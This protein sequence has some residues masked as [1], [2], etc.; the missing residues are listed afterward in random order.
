VYSRTQPYEVG[1]SDAES[2]FESRQ[3]ADKP[4]DRIKSR[5][6]NDHAG[7]ATLA[8]VQVCSL[9]L[10]LCTRPDA[11]VLLG[12]LPTCGHVRSGHVH[13]HLQSLS[14]TIVQHDSVLTINRILSYATYQ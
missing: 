5:D 12:G 11:H 9:A 10:A 2:H 13:P 8:K 4:F 1:P 7:K 3:L 6:H 14:T